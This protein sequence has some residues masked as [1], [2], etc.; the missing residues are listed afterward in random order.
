MYFF[1]LTILSGRSGRELMLPNEILSIQQQPWV[2]LKQ[3]PK[4]L[5]SEWYTVAEQHEIKPSMNRLKQVSK[6]LET[7][8]LGKEDIIMACRD[9][10]K[11]LQSHFISP[12]LIVLTDVEGVVIELFGDK[13]LLKDAELMN[14][15]PDTSL[16]LTDA[17]INGVAVSMLLQNNVCVQGNEHQLLLFQELTCFSSPIRIEG[18]IVGYLDLSV[19]CR[20]KP[21]YAFPLTAG[22]VRSLEIKLQQQYHRKNNIENKIET[23]MF[24]PRE[25]EIADYWLQNKSALF[26]AEKLGIAEGTVRNI[27]KKIYAKS[28]VNDRGDFIRLFL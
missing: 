9:E 11:F 19:P 23:M 20:V 13:K 17:G 28:R 8:F 24:T 26:I 6:P 15:V 14:L 4:R 3:L 21:E 12:W 16:S 22:I 25:K 1:S 18:T 10:A 5:I 27:I 7:G 2:L